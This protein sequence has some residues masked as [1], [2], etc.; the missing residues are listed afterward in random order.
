MTMYPETESG[1]LALADLID[2]VLAFGRR[3]DGEKIESIPRGFKT[4]NDIPEF[5][6]IID[7]L[8]EFQ[9]VLGRL[10]TG[11]NTKE[12][13]MTIPE[14][15][16]AIREQQKTNPPGYCLTPI[17]RLIRDAGGN[18]PI[19]SVARHRLGGEWH[20]NHWAAARLLGL[21]NQDAGEIAEVADYAEGSVLSRAELLA[22]CGLE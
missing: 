3:C 4:F 13:C 11:R 18:C 14:F 15:L 19:E 21:S 2:A 22:A 16:D 12:K 6:A 20:K 8:D 5:S 9:I 1:R 10:P 7:A 17:A